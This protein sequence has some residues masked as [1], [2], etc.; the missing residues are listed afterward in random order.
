[1]EE[2]KKRISMIRDNQ[3][4]T[5]TIEKDQNEQLRQ[6]M[7]NQR[8]LTVEIPK[9]KSIVYKDMDFTETFKN[10]RTL[11][12]Y[13]NFYSTELNK[14]LSQI[15]QKFTGFRE[16]FER[17]KKNFNSANYMRSDQN[18]EL[19]ERPQPE[20]QEIENLSNNLKNL[21]NYHFLYEK[22]NDK[23]KLNQIIN[24]INSE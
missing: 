8:K 9:H 13:S 11:E 19:V 12:L 6:Q 3:Y 1:M 20:F 17:I 4:T 21:Y 16:R 23:E 22:N 14:N 2:T 15:D 5:L 18:P 24:E 10:L 7:E